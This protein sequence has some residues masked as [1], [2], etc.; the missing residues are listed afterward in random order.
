MELINRHHSNRKRPQ[1]TRVKCV[2][3]RQPIRDEKYHLVPIDGN[4]VYEK[5]EENRCLSCRGKIE[6]TCPILHRCL[7]SM[8]VGSGW[9]TGTGLSL[10]STKCENS[11]CQQQ[12]QHVGRGRNL[13]RLALAPASEC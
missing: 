9:D 11:L 12:Q 1:H 7:C 4:I 3:R 5:R 10:C 8:R 2:E 6:F 13:Y